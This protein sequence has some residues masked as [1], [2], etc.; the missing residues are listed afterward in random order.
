MGLDEVVSN[1]G[2]IRI[3]VVGSS[4]DLSLPVGTPFG[5]EVAQ[6][7]HDRRGAGVIIIKDLLGVDGLSI[8]IQEEDLLRPPQNVFLPL[9]FYIRWF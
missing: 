8:E 4:N 2:V 1:H 6:R 9:G 5:Q 7:R 3:S